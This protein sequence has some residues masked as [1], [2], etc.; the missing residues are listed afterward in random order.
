MADLFLVFR[1]VLLTLEARGETSNAKESAVVLD[2]ALEVA[3][4]ILLILNRSP[5]VGSM[6]GI[7]GVPLLVRDG[8]LIRDGLLVRDG[9]RMGRKLGT[10]LGKRL[11]GGAGGL[12][13]VSPDDSSTL[14]RLLLIILETGYPVSSNSSRDFSSELT[15]ENEVTVDDMPVFSERML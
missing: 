4:D 5:G 6:G 13:S 15:T 10:R 3:R 14:S 1:L 12:T 11:G 7:L 2:V 8:L 9:P